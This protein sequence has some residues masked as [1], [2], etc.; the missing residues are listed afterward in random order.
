[1]KKFELDIIALDCL[2]NMFEESRFIPYESFR[3]CDRGLVPDEDEMLAA[4]VEEGLLKKEPYGYQITAK[5]IVFQHKG[6][7][8]EL[9]R[10]ERR[11]FIIAV[12]AA[13]CSFV[14]A[15]ASLVALF[16]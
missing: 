1:M 15:V 8:A 2:L 6:G 14:A 9:A 16:K 11:D 12:I 5:G 3:R 10:R 13:V 7:F 4:L